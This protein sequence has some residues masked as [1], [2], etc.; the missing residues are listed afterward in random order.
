M[1]VIVSEYDI[2]SNTSFLGLFYVFSKYIFSQQTSITS[3]IDFLAPTGLLQATMNGEERFEVKKMTKT[4]E[5][6]CVKQFHYKQ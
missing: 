6:T 4:T 1:E 2:L 5:P 3:I